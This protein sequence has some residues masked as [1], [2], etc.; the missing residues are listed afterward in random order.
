MK[1]DDFKSGFVS[2]IGRPNVGKSTL[3][4]N[5]LGEKI[6]IATHKPQTTRN[7]ITGIKNLPGTQIVFWDTPGIHKAKD[8]MNKAMVKSAVSTLSEVDL[9]LFV[10]ESDRLIGGD[11]EYILS[12]LKQEKTPA[13]LVLNKIDMVKKGELLPI[14]E[15]F[16]GRHEFKDI[17]PVSAKTGEG[18]DIL[19]E[20]ISSYMSPGPR[21]FPDDIVTDC[22]ERFIVSEFVREKVFSLLHEEIPYK[23]AVD[24]EMFREEEKK[25]L[26]VINAVIYVDREPH[27]RIIIGKG[28]ALLKKIG[29]LA[30]KD[31]EALLGAR[32]FL[33]IFVKV[34]K[35]WS[36]SES[37]L[38]EFGIDQH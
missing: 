35:G 27:K 29:T 31:M 16:S 10:V 8:V 2:I 28:G 19:L 11:D 12:L 21:Y 1:E 6:S 34:K 5:I 25:N 38:R 17:I 4:N 32:V 22:P 37:M 13:I 30:R 15:R 23:T 14:I 33:E 26:I 3:L 7:R 24:I 18:V 9:L 36:S 20:K